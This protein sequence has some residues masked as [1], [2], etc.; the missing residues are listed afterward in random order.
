MKYWIRYPIQKRKASFASDSWEIPSH[1]ILKCSIA[2]TTTT[3]SSNFIRLDFFWLALFVWLQDVSLGRKHVTGKYQINYQ[4]DIVYILWIML[5]GYLVVLLAWLQRKSES[6]AYYSS[7]N[8]SLIEG[9]NCN[10]I[11]MHW[12]LPANLVTVTRYSYGG[13]SQASLPFNIHQPTYT[14]AQMDRKCFLLEFPFS[15]VFKLSF[16]LF[17]LLLLLLLL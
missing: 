6:I 1:S 5:I 3:I 4:Y 2:T 11:E 15:P 9:I 17:R 7:H 14:D 8:C 10:R 13:I 16:F 12:M